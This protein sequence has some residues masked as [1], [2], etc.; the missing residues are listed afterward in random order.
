[1][2][3]SNVVGANVDGLHSTGGKISGR[4]GGGSSAARSLRNNLDT[5]SSSVGNGRLKGAIT[6]FVTNGVIDSSNRL[7][8]QLTAAGTNVSN[9]AA[10][11]RNE[12]EEGARTVQADVSTNSAV[13]D[14]IN[15]NVSL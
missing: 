1:M 10:T 3:G 6:S 12:D 4:S 11:V 8:S 2:G 9:V 5:T 15:R 14:R 7:G 13:S